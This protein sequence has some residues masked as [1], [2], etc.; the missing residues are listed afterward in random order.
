MLSDDANPCCASVTCIS[1]MANIEDANSMPV[2]SEE[3]EKKKDDETRA[4]ERE[5]QGGEVLPLIALV[6]G[7]C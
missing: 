4:R 5:E 2:L 3:E 7:M 6:Q 1:A